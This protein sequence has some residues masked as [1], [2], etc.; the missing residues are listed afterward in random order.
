MHQYQKLRVWKLGMELTVDIYELSKELPNDERYGLKSQI[1]R[2]VVAIPSN[3]AEGAGRNSNGEW[4]YFLGIANGSAFELSTQLL[5]C[6][7]LTL[8]SNDQIEPLIS[9]LSRIQN[10]LFRLISSYK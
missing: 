10:M 5:I 4:K 1:T 8:L 3:I 2:A 7:N 6:K 9:K